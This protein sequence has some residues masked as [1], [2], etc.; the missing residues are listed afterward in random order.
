M[1]GRYPIGEPDP[2]GA[3]PEDVALGGEGGGVDDQDDGAAVA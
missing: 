2:V 3:E 1:C